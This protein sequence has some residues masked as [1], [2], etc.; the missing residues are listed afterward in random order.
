VISFTVPA[1]PVAQPR[2]RATTIH[3]A[4]RVFEAKKS[5]PVHAFK[6]AVAL[7]AAEAYAGPPL[8]GPLRVTLICVFPRP[9][10]MRWKNRPQVRVWCEKKPDCDNLAK[11]VLDALNGRCF[12]DDSQVTS[13]MVLKFTAD[14]D[15][16]P[17]V[18]VSVEP[19]PEDGLS[20]VEAER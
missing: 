2:P 13:L 11:S 18:W 5:H 14:G 9:K 15:E 16:Q 20:R 7:A 12:V 10:A 6:A 17:H 3:G 8:E 1:I 19:A 4:A